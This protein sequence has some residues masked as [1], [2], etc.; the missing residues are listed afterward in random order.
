MPDI[1]ITLDEARAKRLSEILDKV[2]KEMLDF[3][4]DMTEIDFDAIEASPAASERDGEGVLLIQLAST[5]WYALHPTPSIDEMRQAELH[6]LDAIDTSDPH[7]PEPPKHLNVRGSD[8]DGCFVAQD[9]ESGDWYPLPEEDQW[10][11]VG[12]KPEPE[13]EP[14]DYTIP[15]ADN[16]DEEIPF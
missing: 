11:Y 5:L 7:Q 15:C 16:C 12:I 10:A 1:T 8:A 9:P 4:P 14:E 13:P 6:N 2:G 3:V